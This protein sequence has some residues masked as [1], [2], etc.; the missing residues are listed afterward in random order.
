MN[1]SARPRRAVARELLTVRVPLTRDGSA[2]RLAR[3]C[4]STRSLVVRLTDEVA[5]PR[6]GVM[7]YVRSSAVP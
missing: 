2:N 3:N 5:D 4:A 7:V 1:V 6:I